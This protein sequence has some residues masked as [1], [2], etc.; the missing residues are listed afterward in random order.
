MENASVKMR[1]LV[2]GANG[3]I[4]IQVCRALLR[5]G[6]QV[7]ALWHRSRERL[8]KLTDDG[9]LQLE[10]GD[11]LDADRLR[12]IV[13]AFSPEGICHLAVQP[14]GGSTRLSHQVNVRGTGNLLEV[15]RRAGVDRL[16][17]ASSM[18]VYNFLS[19]AYL[20]VDEEHP[21]EPLQDYGKEKWA[22]E[23]LCRHQA[24]AGMRIP[25]LRLAGIYGPGK[26]S[27]AVYNFI[28]AVLRNQPV[29]IEQNRRVDLLH[30]EEAARALVMALEGADEIESALLNIGSG[31]SIALD[32]LV[33]AI[34]SEVGR[35]V[36]LDCRENGNEFY[37]DI[38]RAKGML[39]FTPLPLEEGLRRFIPWVEEEIDDVD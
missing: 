23:E 4:G 35:K 15:C 11:I 29:V 28:R 36:R 33:L 25:L 9:N 6:H 12:Q 2:T 31:R 22:A 5:N 39:G 3:F 10:Q 24:R 19:P 32:E 21:L 1:V 16:V 13:S 30:V 17:Y 37:L 14:P 7:L 8:E 34:G 27:G 38:R 20:P 26:R 18:S